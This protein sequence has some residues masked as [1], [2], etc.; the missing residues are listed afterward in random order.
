M[1]AECTT[2]APRAKHKHHPLALRLQ[3]RKE[4]VE[5]QGTL[6]EVAERHGIPRQTLIAWYRR[7]HWSPA[8]ERW[9]AKQMCD[10]D[11]PAKP[12][13]L[14]LIPGDSKEDSRARKVQR[15]ELQLEA[16]DNLIDNAKSADEWHKLATAKHRLLENWYILAGVPKPGSLRHKAERKPVIGSGAYR[17]IQPLGPA[18]VEPLG[19]APSTAF[20][21]TT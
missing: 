2:V 14:A 9:W 3:C 4:W 18:V 12:V 1:S 15:L 11:A 13:A 6:A 16:L 7:D 5:G 10:S 20:S 8:R 19:L 17:Q 21:S